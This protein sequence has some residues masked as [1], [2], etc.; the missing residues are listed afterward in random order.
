MESLRPSG[1]L[2]RGH[3][4]G[5][6]YDRLHPAGGATPLS[7]SLSSAAQPHAHSLPDG[8]PDAHPHAYGHPD[9]D[10]DGHSDADGDRHGDTDA[11][12]EP[13]TDGNADGKSNADRNSDGEPDANGDANGGSAISDTDADSVPGAVPDGRAYCLSVSTVAVKGP[14][15]RYPVAD[16]ALTPPHPRP[17]PPRRR[18]L[19]K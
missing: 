3:S 4:L 14:I 6:L 19:R 15:L 16:G 18:L 9:T 1:G 8:D 7:A 10:P 12:G 13:D 5:Q 17:F 2:C 11:H